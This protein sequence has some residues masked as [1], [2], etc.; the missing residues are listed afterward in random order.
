M[1]IDSLYYSNFYVIVVFSVVDEY[2]RSEVSICCRFIFL[3][4]SEYGG[5]GIWIGIGLEFSSDF[6]FWYI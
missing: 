2:C 5:L 1:Y 3:L 6:N 4:I